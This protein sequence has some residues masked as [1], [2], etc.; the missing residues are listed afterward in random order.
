MP[1][2]DYTCEKCGVRFETEQTFEE[3]DRHVDHERHEALKCPKC[4]S[5]RI[6]R[7]IDAVR[8]ITS[9]KS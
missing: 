8:V 4:G 3:Y 5:K 6:E 1:S 2:Y 9:K 7:C